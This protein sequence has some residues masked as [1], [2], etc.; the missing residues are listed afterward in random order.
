MMRPARGESE[1][2]PISKSLAQPAK[3]NIAVD[4]II[5]AQCDPAF[6]TDAD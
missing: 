1:F 6:S 5:S 4:R 2:V 3:L